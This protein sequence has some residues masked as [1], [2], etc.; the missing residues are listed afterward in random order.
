MTSR[1]PETLEVEDVDQRQ[2]RLRVYS[3]HLNSSS[4]SFG[5]ERT[6]ERLSREAPSSGR[7]PDLS[8]DFG[9]RRTFD[10]GP[11]TECALFFLLNPASD[12]ELKR[13]DDSTRESP[14]ISSSD[15]A[16]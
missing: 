12:P 11:P 13:N 5:L 10:I 7:P 8:F 9:D 2:D 1:N 3:I 6:L 15:R 16:I 14:T 4:S